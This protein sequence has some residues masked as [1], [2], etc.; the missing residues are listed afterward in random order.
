MS[1]KSKKP[2]DIRFFLEGHRN[3]VKKSE[4]AAFHKQRIVTVSDDYTW[5]LWDTTTQNCLKRISLE[6]EPNWIESMPNNR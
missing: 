6:N 3:R 5:G 4:Y 1:V 2:T